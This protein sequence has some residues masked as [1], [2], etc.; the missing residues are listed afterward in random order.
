MS[1]ESSHA[2]NLAWLLRLRWG[3]VAGQVLTILVVELGMRIALPIAALSTVVGIELVTNVACARWLRGNPVVREGMLAGL[4]G[5]DVLLLT[6]LLFLTGGVFNPFSFLYLI[7]I[8]LA[9]VVLRDR[10]TWALVAMSFLSLGSLFVEQGLSIGWFEHPE[11]HAHHLKLHLQG[12]WVA[13]GIAAAFIV[14]F[15]TRVTRD[16]AR[17]EAELARARAAALRSEKLASL[18]TLVAGVAHELA[19]PLSTIAVAAR[20]LERGLA[21]AQITGALGSDA[22]LI[23]QEV[24]RCREILS[25]L[26]EQA[27]QAAGEGFSRVAGETLVQAA[28]RGLPDDER[29]RVRVRVHE[30]SC[31]LHVPVGAV[32]R[33]MRAVIKNALQASPGGSEI[34]LALMGASGG[35]EI[36]VVD[37]GSGMGPDV[38]A[39][40]GEPFF[41]TKEPGQGMGLGLF[42]AR[43]VLERLGGSL[44]LRSQPG[45][46]TEVILRL[47]Q[48][49]LD[50]LPRGAPA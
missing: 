43:A 15:V 20:E 47:P 7:H 29:S 2:P 16:L 18:G 8:A 11:Q 41:T 13:F 25:Q 39:R 33:T 48:E 37:H 14:Y 23:R 32:A 44:A 26:A 40:A 35:C 42:L 31:A 49:G 45:T 36:R 6:V 34:E 38:L 19:T 46:G 1:P 4:L 22:A 17:R 3:A 12:M 10:W 50:L 30:P 21:A 24:E 5:L 9:A 27:G 28:L